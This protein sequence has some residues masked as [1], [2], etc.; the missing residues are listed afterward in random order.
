MRELIPLWGV[1][2]MLKIPLFGVILILATL[3]SQPTRADGI[4]WWPFAPP[5]VLVYDYPTPLYEPS[6]YY[7]CN[8]T[9]CRR[10]VLRGEHWHSAIACYR[11]QR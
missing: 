4:Y 9:C 10:P 7:R 3:L 1:Y 5:T 2:E 6:G 8:S 11:S